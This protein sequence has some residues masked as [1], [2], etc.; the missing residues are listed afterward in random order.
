MSQREEA[1]ELIR[2]SNRLTFLTGAGVSVASGIPDYR[3]MGGVYEGIEEPEYLLSHS[4]LMAEPKKFY[5]FVKQLY[6][7]KAEP[8]VSH[9]KMAELATKKTVRI[10]TQNID[11]LHDKAGSQVINFHGSLYECYCLGCGQSVSVGDY[12]T[13]DRHV[14]CGGQI[15]PNV[16]LYEENLDSDI[17]ESAI[18]VVEEAEVL[19]IVGT[20]FKVYP[21]SDLLRFKRPDCK[22][23]VVN[24]E[25]LSLGG[26]YLMITED[27]TD[28]FEE[29]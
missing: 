5:E 15:R 7:L 11:Q 12:L 2:G 23:V 28:F 24:N 3:S 20:S 26:D 25:A 8:N 13:S 27:A 6:H 9:R 21:F 17:I 18:Q 1:I 29:L 4:C 19:V 16:V 22:V 14:G 10:V